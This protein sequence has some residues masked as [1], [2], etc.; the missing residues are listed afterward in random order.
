MSRLRLSLLLIATCSYALNLPQLAS[1]IL[2]ATTYNSSSSEQNLIPNLNNLTA[3]STQQPFLNTTAL[4]LPPVSDKVEVKCTFGHELEYND[5]LDALHQF[6][7]PPFRNLTIGPRRIAWS[8]LDLALPVRW[9]S[10][11]PVFPNPMEIKASYLY[12]SV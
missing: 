6:L 2:T 9:L 1:N 3:A 10:G 4:D 7:Y 5:C 8:P 12:A 11:K